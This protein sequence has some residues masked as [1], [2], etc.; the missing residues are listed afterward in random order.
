MPLTLK[1]LMSLSLPA[2]FPFM[3][4]TVNMTYS[5]ARYTGEMQ[6]LAAALVNE[7]DDTREEI[8]RL[9]ERA[10]ELAS[11]AKALEEGSDEAKALRDEA[12]TLYDRIGTLEVALDSRQRTMI[13]EHLATLLLSWDVLGDD[14]KPLPTD[15]ATLKTLPDFFL[16]IAYLN[17]RAENSADPQKAPSSENESSTE[18]GSA[19]SLTGTGSSPQPEPS[20]SPRSSSTNGRT[21]RASTRSGA[22][23]R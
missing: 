12:E 3:G 2:S 21:A 13:R 22:S 20:E 18:K 16:R 19:P 11:E 5:P 15:I 10:E 23:G 17:L 14:G 9:R 8:E 6:D 1:K 4:D 7:N